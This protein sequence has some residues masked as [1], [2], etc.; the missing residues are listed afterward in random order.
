LT[1]SLAISVPHQRGWNFPSGQ[2]FLWGAIENLFG[3]TGETRDFGDVAFIRA[4]RHELLFYQCLIEHRVATVIR[5]HIY[6]VRPRKGLRGVDLISHALPFGWL[7]YGKP[8][9]SSKAVS[10]AKF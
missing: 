7:S 10:Y 6:E 8:N 9:A 5:I 4:I 3:Q 1:F 2:E